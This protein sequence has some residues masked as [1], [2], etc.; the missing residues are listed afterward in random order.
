MANFSAHLYGGAA[1]SSLGALGVY[2]LGWADP[3]LTQMLF[4]V[5]VAGSLLPDIDA[6]DSSPVRGFFTLLGV[7]SAFLVSF[8]LIERFLLLDLAL[9]WTGVFLF[10]RY[11]VFEVFARFTVHRGVWHS[12]LAAGFA[13]LAAVNG[14]FH[15]AGFTAWDSWLVGM[16]VALGYL[17][18]LCQDEIASVDLLSNRVKRSFGTAFKPF[19]TAAPTASLVMFLAASGLAWL[20]PTVDP[21]LAAAGNLQY[22]SLPLSFKVEPAVNSLP[23]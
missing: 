3:G 17:A 14:A 5:G 9:L 23:W 15:F 13:A 11:G 7:I 2:A 19:S 21:V 6:D 8:A 18:H 22:D 4:F 1:V 12:W 20:A 10:V 16:F